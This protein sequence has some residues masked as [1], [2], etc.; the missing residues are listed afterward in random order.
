MLNLSE[1]KKDGNKPRKTL[2]G[3]RFAKEM[4]N[5]HGSAHRM[6]PE[7]PSTMSTSQHRSGVQR[8]HSQL[9]SFTVHDI[10]MCNP[11]SSTK[12]TYTFS[13]NSDVSCRKGIFRYS[14]LETFLLEP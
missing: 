7:L 2:T 8:L 11:V 3:L 13:D 1:T 10:S 9:R 14:L 6:M 12:A 4:K 5:D